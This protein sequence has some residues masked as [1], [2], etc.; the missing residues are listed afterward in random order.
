[1]VKPH[2]TTRTIF[3]TRI[4]KIKKSNKESLVHY[5]CA[6][7]LESRD[8]EYAEAIRTFSP[9]QDDI[10]DIEERFRRLKKE[11]MATRKFSA[12]DRLIQLKSEGSLNEYLCIDYDICNQ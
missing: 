8:E 5:L 11:A 3:S 12:I 10:V 1:M 6:L 4:K 9:K 7:K 2:S